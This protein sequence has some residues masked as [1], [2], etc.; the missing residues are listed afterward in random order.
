ME[1]HHVDATVRSLELDLILGRRRTEDRPQWRRQRGAAPRRAIPLARPSAEQGSG[2]RSAAILQHGD[3]ELIEYNLFAPI[4]KTARKRPDEK[5][6]PSGEGDY[7]LSLNLQL[8]LVM[9]D[10]LPVVD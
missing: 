5:L 3:D 8:P 6:Q 1:L 9:Q 4:Y 7:Q 10:N 2:L